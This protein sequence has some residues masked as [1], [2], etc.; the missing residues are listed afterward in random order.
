MRNLEELYSSAVS[1]E[2]NIDFA[3]LK[4]I[5]E[6]NKTEMLSHIRTNVYM[7]IVARVNK[8]HPYAITHGTAKDPR[9][10]TYVKEEVRGERRK[11]RANTEEELYQA[12]FVFYYGDYLKR[13][14]YSLEQLFPEWIKYKSTTA[15]RQNTVKKLYTDYRRYYVNEELSKKILTKPLRKLTLVDIQEWA[16]AMIKEYAFTRQRFTNVF[17]ILRQAMDYMVN[18]NYMKIN[19][20]ANVNIRPGSFKKARKKPADS[21]IF[22]PDETQEMIDYALQQARQTND[23]VFLAVPILIYSGMRISEC[24]GLSFDDFER[25]KNLIH[26][27]RSMVTI[28]KLLPNGNWAPRRFEIQEYLK[29]NADPR[30]VLV[31]DKCFEIVEKIRTILQKK[32]IKREMLFETYTP[33]NLRT[34]VYRMCRDLEIQQRSP[35]KF[36]KTFISRLINGGADV[37]FVREQAGHQQIATT[38]NA[39]VFS[40]TRDEEKINLLNSLS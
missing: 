3:A 2:L 16:Y 13:I 29:Q 34:K 20:C 39:Y 38:Y 12:L 36:R 15:N 14:D 21:Q 22:F 30:D 18:N 31:C 24:L 28:D 27:H 9:W 8:I 23:E 25:E 32:G 37:D 10:Y 1:K 19:I 7:N 40:T 6:E 5:D 35:H 26:I 33:N 11:I 4:L 17:T